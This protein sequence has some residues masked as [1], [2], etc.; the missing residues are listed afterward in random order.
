LRKVLEQYVKLGGVYGPRFA[1]TIALLKGGSAGTGAAFRNLLA[2]AGQEDPLMMSAQTQMFD[3]LYLGPAFQWA[4]QHG[5]ARQLSYLVIA[6]SFLHSGSMLDSLM[7]RFAERKP[8]VG[9]KE[10]IWIHDYT[11]V[12]R[13]WLATNARKILHNTVYRCDCYLTEIKRDN[14]NLAQAPVI[15][16]GTKVDYGTETEIS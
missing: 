7:N 14:W 9:G 10:E 8:S 11:N 5:F 3:T 2:E 15:M 4:S 12:R 16:N 1:A 6:D 13:N